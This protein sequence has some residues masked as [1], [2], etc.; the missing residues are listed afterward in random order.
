MPYPVRLT[1][2]HGEIVHVTQNE[3]PASDV[4]DEV[5]ARVVASLQAAFDS[6]KARAGYPSQR[7]DIR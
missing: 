4:V 2:A 1:F 3:D 7:L 5:H 6:A